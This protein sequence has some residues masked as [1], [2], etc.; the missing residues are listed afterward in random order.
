MGKLNNIPIALATVYLATGQQA[1]W[2]A[3]L[4]SIIVED[5][6]ELRSQGY[7]ISIWGDF[8]GHVTQDNQGHIKGTDQNGN[9]LTSLHEEE[10]LE[11]I[12]FSIKCEGSWTWARGDQKSTVDYVAMDTP[13]A[14]FV[15]EMVI[16][17]EA[18]TWTLGGDHSFIQIKMTGCIPKAPTPPP[19]QIW[20]TPME[21]QW[22]EYQTPIAPIVK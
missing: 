5:M 12:N 14:L 16:D 2:N 21:K 4:H 22:S 3:R 10:H 20:R 13:L 7:L 9:F 17:E 18:N 8:N 15:D 11:I 6:H 19:R 1:A